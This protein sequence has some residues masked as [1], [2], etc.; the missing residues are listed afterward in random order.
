VYGN[1]SE[2]L[3]GNESESV[4][5]NHRRAQYDHIAE[6]PDTFQPCFHRTGDPAFDRSWGEVL[7]G[8]CAT[9]PSHLGGGNSRRAR[10][11]LPENVATD[12]QVAVD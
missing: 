9:G 2:R 8:L 5:G 1:R 7:I 6:R 3:Y 12:R 11:E 10:R 4:Y